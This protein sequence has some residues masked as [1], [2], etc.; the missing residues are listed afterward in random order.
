M[1]TLG[2]LWDRLNTGIRYFRAYRN[3]PSVAIARAIGRF[4]T[5]AILRRSRTIVT[6]RSASEA[7]YVSWYESLGWR[8]DSAMNIVY[9]PYNGTLPFLGGLTGGDLIG[10]FATRIYDS[11]DVK[12]R[13]VIDIGASIGDSAIY[14][15]LQGAAKVY[16]FEPEA[17]ACNQAAQNVVNNGVSQS[18]SMVHAGLGEEFTTTA[19]T[20]PQ[21]VPNGEVP[22]PSHPRWFASLNDVVAAYDV[23]DGILKMD[24]E[25]CEYPAL[26]GSSLALQAFHQVQIEYHRGIQ[27]LA[28]ILEHSGFAIRILPR[29]R[30]TGEILGTRVRSSGPR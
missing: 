1:S 27:D 4:P 19:H 10:V 14:F 2:P 23:R 17:Q 20:E 21:G 7:Y 9:V 26:S 25:G 24:C 12:G 22:N 29:S 5:S 3:F 8:Y 6:L 11:L 30:S 15:A 13:V 28:A 18:V 16:A